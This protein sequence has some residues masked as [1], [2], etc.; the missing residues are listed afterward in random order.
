L[1]VRRLST[2][3]PFQTACLRNL[4][5]TNG[6]IYLRGEKVEK[7]STVEEPCCVDASECISWMPEDMFCARQVMRV[8][9]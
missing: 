2:K 1:E 4:A 9:L 5:A 6:I 8:S 3:R 7:V